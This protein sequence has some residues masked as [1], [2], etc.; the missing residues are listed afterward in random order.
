MIAR[1]GIVLYWCGLAVASLCE[2]SAIVVFVIIATNNHPASDAWVAAA[3]FT[4]FGDLARRSRREIH[5]SGNLASRA[6]FARLQPRIGSN[7][8]G[9]N[10]R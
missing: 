3:L 1:F 6:A 8:A 4:I 5:S 7:E 9:W 10:R 2:I